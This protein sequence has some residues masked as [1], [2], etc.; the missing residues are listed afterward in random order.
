MFVTVET[1]PKV[2]LVLNEREAQ[3]VEHALYLASQSR[4]ADAKPI[5]AEADRLQAELQNVMIDRDI[6]I[7]GST[8]E[9]VL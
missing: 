2:T 3:V 8:G 5:K 7:L 4:G 1:A 9:L 6:I